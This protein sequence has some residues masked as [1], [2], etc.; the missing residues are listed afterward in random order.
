MPVLF[1]FHIQHKQTF[2]SL[3][4][5]TKA[6]GKDNQK[7]IEILIKHI[8]YKHDKTSLSKSNIQCFEVLDRFN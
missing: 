5:K 6:H 8:F 1:D 2:S 4:K 7:R 3:W